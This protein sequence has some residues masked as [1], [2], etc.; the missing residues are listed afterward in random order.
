M[1]TDTKLKNLKPQDKLYKVSDRDGLY[2]AVLTSGTVSFRYDYR[3]NGRRETLVIGQYGRDGISLAEAREEL[4]AAKKLLK[5]GQS[6]AAAK[7]DG[8]KKI[9]GAETFAVHTDSYMKHVILAD[10]T[11]AMKQA[12]IDRDILPVL[13]NKMMAEITTSMVRDLCDRIVERGGRA[14]AVQSREIISSVYRHANDRGHGLFNPAADIKP[15][16]IAIFKPR[17]RTLTPEEIGLF[18]RTLDAIGAMGTMKM[19]L[20]LVLITMVRKGEFTNATWDEIDFKKWTWTIPSDRMKGSRAHVIYLPKQAQ[21]ILVGLQMCAGGS[22]YL[23]PG[24]Y[25]FRKPLSNAALNSL[26][27]RTV[28]IINEDGEHIQGFT[29]HDM[30]RTASTLL[31]EA[32][33]PSDWIE[34]ALA[35]EQKG[36]RAVYNKAE[37][38]RQRAYMLQQWADMI[39]SWINGEHTDLIPFS[40]SK[41]EKWMAGE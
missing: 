41:F 27:D 3:I 26:I 5:A 21:D 4:I 13:G 14:T 20:K 16:S 31:H 7:R 19:A 17:E 29:V 33:Y 40:P 11:R 30:R 36:V 38:A 15:S 6:P 39:D 23:V 12:V 2:V 10:S 34:K 22:E 24:R 8:I 35:H 28:K 18:F 1:L 32:G 37:Y 25:N 9:R